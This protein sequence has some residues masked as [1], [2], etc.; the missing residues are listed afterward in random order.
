MVLNELERPDPASDDPRDDPFPNEPTP[1]EAE[2]PFPAEEDV[3][4][5]S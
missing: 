5:E 3:R 1:E 2:V 4:G